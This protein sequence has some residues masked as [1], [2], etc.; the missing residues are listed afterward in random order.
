M[1]E[2]SP[3][4]LEKYVQEILASD[5]NLKWVPDSVEGKI[6]FS[7]L[8]TMLKLLEKGLSDTHI[9]LLGHRITMTIKPIPQDGSQ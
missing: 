9:D 3:Q 4:V 5:I 7:L 8:Q 6:Y 2:I 1:S